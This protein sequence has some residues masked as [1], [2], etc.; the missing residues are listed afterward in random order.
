MGERRSAPMVTGSARVNALI[1]AM[2]LD[3]KLQVVHGGWN[4]TWDHFHDKSAGYDMRRHENCAGFIAGI[5]ELGIPDVYV[6]DGE[7]GINTMKDATALPSKV[8][9]AA[10]FDLDAAQLHGRVLGKEAKASGVHVVLSPRVNIA[11]APVTN[12]GE[13]NGGN[14]QTFGEDPFLN[15]SMGAAEAIGIQA[16]GNAIATVKQML[17]SSNGTAQGVE[18]VV[19][20]EQTMHEIYMAPF[21]YVVSAGVGAA[22]TNYN[23]IN[24]V[25]TTEFG[26]MNNTMMR[27]RWGFQGFI[28]NDWLCLERT[29]AMRNG[30]DLEMPGA[31]VFGDKLRSEILTGEFP[32]SLLDVSVGRILCQLERFGMLD[33]PRDINLEEIDEEL[34]AESAAAALRLAERSAVLL[35]NDAA[36]LPLRR[37]ESLA[38]IGAGAA[39]FV[40]PTFKESAFG[41][42]DRRVSARSALEQ[43]LGTTIPFAM[44]VDTHGELV[45][46]EA[47]VAEDAE[48]AGLTRYRRD[49]GEFSPIGVDSVIDMLGDRALE[50]GVYEWRGS[51]VAPED[52]DYRIMMH[53]EYPSAEVARANAP[54]PYLMLGMNGDMWIDGKQVSHG[55]RVVLNG[56][57]SPNNSMVTSNDGLNNAKAYLHLEKGRHSIRIAAHAISAQPVGVRLNW[58]TPSMHEKNISDAAAL[59]GSVDKAV[60]FVWHESSNASFG[61]VGGQDELISA[62]AAANP[63]TI[64][65]LNTGDPVAMPWKDDVQGILEM[66]YPGQEGGAAT[67]N[68]LLGLTNPGGK[69]PVTFPTALDKTPVLDPAHPERNGPAGRA[70]PQGPIGPQG[71]AEF[72]EGVDVGYRWYDAN[73]VE[74]LFP[75]GFGLSYTTFAYS[76]LA[77]TVEPGGWL[78]VQFQIK[79]TGAVDGSEVAQAYVRR[80]D[81]VPSG[82]QMP[83]KLLAA[84][85]RVELTAG[86]ERAVTVEI[87]R[88]RLSYWDVKRTDWT[89]PRSERVVLIGA[90]SRDIRLEETTAGLAQAASKMR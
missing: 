64:V 21:E 5:P 7:Y 55:E 4:Y 52:G 88:Q 2:T 68:I 17:G 56:S 83:E 23:R 41:F 90:S 75:F 70:G 58:V 80:P 63:R 42:P 36:A 19:M 12:S 67:A 20:N 69:L 74:P 82:V 73:E 3:Q 66:W 32:E 72:T 77:V 50:P 71:V 35:K 30:L 49:A 59:A 43:V 47:L 81:N 38:L 16:D 27:E 78:T 14:F 48:S 89:L 8:G 44:G 13:S 79:N 53:S 10:T 18:Y 87:P 86:E 61:L 62:V 25:W 31:R 76:N 65:V 54:D 37:E 26:R 28:V 22:M 60:V 45:P 33:T 9:L 51:L 1:E 24:G 29:N 15:G 34:K 85:A 84:F 46:A 11:R 39:Q 57:P 40:S 6:A